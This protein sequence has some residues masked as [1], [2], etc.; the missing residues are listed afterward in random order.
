MDLE[1]KDKVAIVTGSSRGI[2]RAIALGLAA[3]GARVVLTARGAERLAETVREV[4]ALGVAAL[5][6]PVDLTQPDAAERVVRAAKEAF[7]RVDILV[8][9][10]GG[11][12][13]GEDDAAW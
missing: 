1:L 7:G 4:E 13:P 10:V 2:G 12:F 9:N 6:V 11:A 3:E 5:G 8:N